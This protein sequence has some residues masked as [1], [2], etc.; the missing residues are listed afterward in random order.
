LLS[1]EGSSVDAGW[2]H[3]A[4][5]KLPIGVNLNRSLLQHLLIQSA[6]IAALTQFVSSAKSLGQ[7][8]KL[9][10]LR[11]YGNIDYR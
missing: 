1:A 3:T 10:T 7:R 4:R 9:Q 11:L 2:D 8:Q 6:A 5:V